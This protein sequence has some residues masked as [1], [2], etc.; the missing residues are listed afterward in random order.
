MFSEFEKDTKP[1]KPLEQL[2]GVFPAASG[3]FLP[4]TWRNLM[5]SADS[6]IIDFYPDDFAIDLNGK[7]YAWQG[8]ALL[9]FVD[10]RRLRAAL[11]EVYPD[12]TTDEGENICFL[13]LRW[14]QQNFIHT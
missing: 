14:F 10:E 13:V 3:N 5:M 11:A 6:S 4:L 9:P 1:F 12:L 2:M 7:K 8:V